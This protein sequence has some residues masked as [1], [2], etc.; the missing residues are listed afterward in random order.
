MLLTAYMRLS[1]EKP[2]IHHIHNIAKAQN[3][4]RLSKSNNQRLAEW[5]LGVIENFRGYE[6][7]AIAVEAKPYFNYLSQ[8][9]HDYEEDLQQNYLDEDKLSEEEAID[10]IYSDQIEEE[11]KK[12]P[13][14]IEAKIECG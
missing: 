10:M 2:G 9:H 8:L 3:I 12:I 7:T 14:K 11:L 6:N 4:E 13:S 1:Y 5:A